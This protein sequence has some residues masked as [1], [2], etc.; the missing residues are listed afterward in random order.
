M[1]ELNEV[2]RMVE[3]MARAFADKEVAPK[4]EALESGE[5]LPYEIMRDMAGKFG[6][7]NLMQ[8]GENKDQKEEGEEKEEAKGDE[9]GGLFGGIGDP[10]LA[11]I[12][13]KELSRVSPGF[14][15]AMGASV[16]LSGGT[17]M[18]KGTPP[19][20]EKYGIPV[21]TMEKVGCWGMSEPGSGS[22]A[23]A[24]T[25]TA[26]PKDDGYVLNGSKTFITNSPY[27]DV[28]VIYAKID[29]GQADKRDKRFIF[30]FVMEKGTPGLTASKPFKKMGM[31]ASPTGEVFLDDVFVKKDQLLGESEEKSARDQAKD[32]FAGERS[33]APSMAWGI[34]ERCL[35]ESIKYAVQRKQW[36]KPIAEFQLI[37]E[38]IAKMY[39]ALEN[40]R[41]I[42]FKM[43]WAGKNKK[44]TPEDQC[45]AKYYCANAAVDVAMEAIQLMGGYGFMEEY[46]VE[47]LMR[48]AKLL[49]IGGGTDEIQLLTI[50]KQL[51]RKYDYEVTISGSK[52]FL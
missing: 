18:A 4:V 25:T 39:V 34:I 7:K 23:F 29:R 8:Q 38:K 24:L 3:Q 41:N 48:D 11:A 28:F 15:L 46:H 6:I 36:G 37:Q 52:E 31:R 47:R 51:L 26:K 22:D 45:V 35:E 13:G 30:P 27:A 40:V 43:A 2:Q 14:C 16:G 49:C 10:L 9:G 32:V 33:G 12:V 20:K 5:V 44:A 17:I 19:Q 42:A 1:F 50:A 21:I